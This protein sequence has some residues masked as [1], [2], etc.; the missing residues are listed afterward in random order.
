MNSCQLTENNERIN[1][2]VNLK[3]ENASV[4][5]SLITDNCILFTKN[6]VTFVTFVTFGIVKCSKTDEIKSNRLVT[7]VHKRVTFYV[8]VCISLLPFGC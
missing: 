8:Q 2:C 3:M 1:Q 6:T 5:F 7:K 4:P